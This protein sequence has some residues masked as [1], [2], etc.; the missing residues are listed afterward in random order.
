MPKGK[1]ESLDVILSKC[2]KSGKT[3]SE[4]EAL[5]SILSARSQAGLTQKQVAKLLGTTQSA[6]ARMEA[7]F[8][9]GK[10]PSVTMLQKY[11][12]ALGRTLELRFY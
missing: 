10:Y 2:R 5:A 11:A 7:N 8:A 3:P 6:I 9:R 1:R 12:K 4:V